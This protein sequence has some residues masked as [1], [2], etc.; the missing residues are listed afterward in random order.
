[1][2]TIVNGDIAAMIGKLFGVKVA[3][4]VGIVSDLRSP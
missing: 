3:S 1:M 2:M 4:R